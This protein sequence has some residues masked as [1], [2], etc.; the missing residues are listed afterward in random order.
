MSCWDGM[1]KG[2]VAI[3]L[4]LMHLGT[5]VAS[6]SQATPT[7]R[8]SESRADSKIKPPIRPLTTCPTEIEPLISALL[9]DLPE[10]INRISHQQGGSQAKRY[11]IAASQ[12]DL[13]PLPITYSGSPHSPDSQLHQSF[14]TVLERQYETQRRQDIQQFHWLILAYSSSTGWQLAT[15]Y[16]RYGSHPMDNQVPSAL[17]ETSQG[18]TG[19]AIR[20]W[21]RDCQAGAIKPYSPNLSPMPTSHVPD[22]DF[23]LHSR[24]A[25]RVP[26]R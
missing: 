13:T 18:V 1:G 16:S 5:P 20:R 21:L 12:A 17:R 4:T 14:F 2:R 26:S 15:L 11:A 19:R 22:R 9:R 7:T 6:I 3:A 10:Y 23:W 8:P 24:G 25:A